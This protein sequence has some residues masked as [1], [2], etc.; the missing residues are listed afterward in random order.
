LIDLHTHST[1]SD[2]T[3][4]PQEIIKKARE[5]GL[6]AISI[7]DHDNA[8]GIEDALK[9]SEL[10]SF[11][12]I[13]G[14]EL[15]SVPPVYDD[16]IKNDIESIKSF[17]I[18]FY[19]KMFKSRSFYSD[20]RS[21]KYYDFFKNTF[22]PYIWQEDEKSIFRLRD[23]I[24][25]NEIFLIAP[26]SSLTQAEPNNYSNLEELKELAE[27]Y[28]CSIIIPTFQ[29]LLL[30]LEWIYNNKFKIN[31][32]IGGFNSYLYV[33]I[34]ETV[35]EHQKFLSKYLLLNFDINSPNPSLFGNVEGSNSLFSCILN[36]NHPII[37]FLVENEK[38]LGEALRIVLEDFFGLIIQYKKINDFGLILSKYGEVIDQVNLRFNKSF[39]KNFRKMI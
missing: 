24:E 35:E 33:D 30:Y 26:I 18:N 17:Y 5:K 22:Y 15:S 10:H 39:G 11:E 6:E 29:T 14:I 34:S 2:G 4:T 38:N 8:F 19:E 23:F 1:F 21:N 36:K 7:T 9:A 13:P 27:E 28:S 32:I 20:S 12:V 16:F 25:Q 31:M 3:D 37:N